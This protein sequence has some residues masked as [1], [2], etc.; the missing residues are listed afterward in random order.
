MCEI[1]C[2]Y[3]THPGWRDTGLR[4]A[5][6]QLPMVYESLKHRVEGPLMT[7]FHAAMYNGDP[8]FAGLPD[9]ATVEDVDIDA[10]RHWLEPELEEGPIEITIVGTV[11]VAKA[12]ADV[13]R[14]F[15]KLSKRREWRTWDDRRRPERPRSGLRMRREID[16]QLDQAL[17]YISYPTDDGLDRARRRRL[18]TLGQVLNDRVRVEIRERLGA[19]YSP[20]ANATA[21]TVFHGHGECTL[22]VSCSPAAVDDVVEAALEIGRDLAEHGPREEELRRVIEPL[23]ARIRDSY[24][25][26]AA[27]AGYLVDAQRNP[28]SLDD[29]RTHRADFEAMTPEDLRPYAAR[30]LNP[31][32]ASILVVVPAGADS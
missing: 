29:T 2:A 28:D 13:A 7:E 20:Q 31:E 17:V 18:V 32:Q 9:L 14:T 25:T 10:V 27:W 6:Q 15:G 16:T 8:R 19:S 23:V 30:Y 5:K 22:T 24:R 3:L 26:N 21:S 12:V 1:L 4:M 11:E